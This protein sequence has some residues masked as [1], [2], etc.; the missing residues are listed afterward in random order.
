MDIPFPTPPPVPFKRLIT[1]QVCTGKI[2]LN[3]I[4]NVMQ[5]PIPPNFKANCETL[6][7]ARSDLLSFSAL[8]HDSYPLI[9]DYIHIL[10]VVTSTF[11]LSERKNFSLKFPWGTIAKNE[12]DFEIC[13]M[14]YNLCV[15]LLMSCSQLLPVDYS[16]KQLVPQIKAAKSLYE[17]CKEHY[18]DQYSQA[19][20][21]QTLISMDIYITTVYYQIQHGVFI[22]SNKTKIL[23][24]S[25][26]FV[27]QQFK[28][29]RI[30]DPNYEKYYDAVTSVYY[31]LQYYDS[32]DY[33]PCIAH[34]RRALSLIPSNP[35]QATG[36]FASIW[37]RLKSGFKP[38]AAK[39]EEE[40]KKIYMEP[41]SRIDPNLPQIEPTKVIGNIN[42]DE[43]KVKVSPFE[44]TMDGQYEDTIEAKLAE[45]KASSKKALEDISATLQLIPKNFIPSLDQKHNELLNIRNQ[46]SQLFQQIES[47]N[48]VKGHQVNAKF[49]QIQQKMAENQASFQK[50]QE[51]DLYYET[52]FAQA[53]SI[54]DIFG[55]KVNR[56]ENLKESIN[57]VLSSADSAAANAKNSKDLPLQESM[58]IMQDMLNEFASL[59]YQL[60][61]LLSETFNACNES[62]QLCSQSAQQ[63]STFSSA[64]D[65]GFTEGI[66]CYQKLITNFNSIIAYFNQC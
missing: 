62:K 13:C 41:V 2:L 36:Q 19:I 18:N 63:Y 44:V 1:Q 21:S 20:S 58:R 39:Y 8:P 14:C 10:K 3:Y 46:A 53:S 48:R 24:K 65:L 22:A 11:D 29:A 38:I 49:P 25:A 6:D 45:F 7:K 15:G 34:V 57:A 54:Y 32:K 55:P 61:P 47:L 43:Y 35:N 30:A 12:I 64:A 5:V 16:L 59:N 23:P 51:A 31:A 42:F 17:K 66:K 26:Y 52:Q 4:T 33:G 37:S 56:L 27:S 28:K 40:N 50:A 60:N 9:S